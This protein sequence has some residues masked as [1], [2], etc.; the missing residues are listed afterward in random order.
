M[1]NFNYQWWT[2]RV[3]LHTGEYTAEVKAKSREHAIRQIEREVKETNSEKNLSKPLWE[4]KNPILDVYWDTL[5]L[6]RTGYQ[7]L[8]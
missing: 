1:S 6:D 8:S 5:T 2:V 7:R 3:K 4:R